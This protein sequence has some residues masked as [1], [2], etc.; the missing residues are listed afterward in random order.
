MALK[1][2]QDWVNVILGV[3]MVV[4][5]WILGFAADQNV[6]AQ[7]AW[8]LGVAI[9][10]FAGIAVYIHKAWE[11]AINIIL[12]ICLIASP[13]VLGFVDQ[14]T[15]TTNAVIVGFLV[16]AFGLWSMFMDTGVQKWWHEHYGA[17]GTR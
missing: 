15:A 10:V 13:W 7:T 5:P 14:M 9:I 8:V 4:S 2:W 1:R 17:H 3:W 11:E 16:T 6:A 12:G